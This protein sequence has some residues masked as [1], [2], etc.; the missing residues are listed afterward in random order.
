MALPLPVTEEDFTSAVLG[1]VVMTMGCKEWAEEAF[2]EIMDAAGLEFAQTWRVSGF[3]GGYV[4]A[5]LKSASLYQYS[6]ST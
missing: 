4:E 2:R 6:E 5:R 1:Q 3:P